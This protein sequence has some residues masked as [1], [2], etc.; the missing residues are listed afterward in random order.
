MM[1]ADPELVTETDEVS[2]TELDDLELEHDTCNGFAFAYLEAHEN[3][4]VVVKDAM[5]EGGGV[6]HC[7][8]R[9]RTRG[10]TIDVTLGQFSVGPDAGAWEGD[11]PFRVQGEEVREWTSRDEFEA[12]YSDSDTANDFIV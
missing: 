6:A 7:Y 1:K 8:V 4:D 12:F 10:V 5:I 2:T 11:H 9:D 3:N